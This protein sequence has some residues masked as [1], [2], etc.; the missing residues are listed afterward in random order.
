MAGLRPC[1]GSEVML[2]SPAMKELTKKP[3]RE[4]SR[5]NPRH[6]ERPKAVVHFC[7]TTGHDFLGVYLHWLGLDADEACLLCGHERIDGNHLLQ[8]TGL[9]E[10]P[11]EYVV[12]R[13][14][15]ARR[16]MVKKSRMGV[17]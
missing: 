2:G 1:S 9:D 12:G 13:Y 17:G 14:W 16:Q 4:P 5:L 11:T 10:Y 7:L 6:L 3:N 15:K 8:C